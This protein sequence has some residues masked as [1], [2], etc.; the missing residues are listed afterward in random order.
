MLKT[1]TLAYKLGIK[2]RTLRKRAG[3]TQEQLAE[4]AEVSVNFI[5]YIERGQRAVSIKTLERIA[6]A[7]DVTP[8]NLFEFS[9]GD[10]DE[11]SYEAL[12]N[13]LR[14]CTRADLLVL[15]R[16]AAR[17]NIA[18]AGSA[19]RAEK[20]TIAAAS[21][22]WNPYREIHGSP[23]RALKHAWDKGYNA[24]DKEIRRPEKDSTTKPHNKNEEPR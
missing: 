1:E 11:S 9:E 23:D 17:L 14:N 3:L 15:T 20:Q 22:G 7:L 13:E 21:E 19:A 6:K 10:I 12:L 24:R 2:I 8:R 5:G 4:A 18:N 16:L